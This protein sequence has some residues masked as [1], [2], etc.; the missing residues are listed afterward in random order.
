MFKGLGKFSLL[1]GGL[2]LL[3]VS[4]AQGPVNPAGS[5]GQAMAI[6][7]ARAYSHGSVLADCHRGSGLG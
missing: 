6:P 5:D 4:C 2:S 3:V 7:M 1:L